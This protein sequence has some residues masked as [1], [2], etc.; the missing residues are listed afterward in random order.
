MSKDRIKTVPNLSLNSSKH[1]EALSLGKDHFRLWDR[2][3]IDRFKDKTTEEIKF[4]LK[5]TALPFAVLMENWIGDFN[6]SSLVRNSNGFN[7]K[8]VFYLGDKKWDK[9]GAQGTY[10]Y[11][12]VN[13]LSSIDD[14]IKLKEKYVFVGLDNITNS[15]PLTT[16]KW[17]PN[18]LMIFGSEGTGLTQDIIDLCQDIVHIPMTGSV[19]SFNCSTASGIVMYDYITKFNQ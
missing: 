11:T 1:Q 16:Y 13:F 7:A 8:E 10:H 14:L 2:N 5:S 15:V 12:D 18:S 4:E 6:F 9:R 17:S 3:V 19:R